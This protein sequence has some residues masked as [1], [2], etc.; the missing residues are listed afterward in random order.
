VADP[1]AAQEVRVRLEGTAAKDGDSGILLGRATN[2]YCQNWVWFGLA[3][4]YGSLGN[5]AAR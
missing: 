5:L 1:A 3:L 2:Y 4:A